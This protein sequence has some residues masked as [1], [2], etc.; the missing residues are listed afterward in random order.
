[1]AAGVAVAAP[2]EEWGSVIVAVVVVRTGAVLSENDVKRHVAARLPRYMVP[3]RVEVLAE[4]P[5]TTTGK[6]D[7]QLLTQLVTNGTRADR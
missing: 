3:D 5:R 7:R 4:L 1:V 2:H 6:V